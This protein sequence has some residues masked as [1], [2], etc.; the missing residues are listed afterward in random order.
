MNDKKLKNGL[1]ETFKKET[2]H[3]GHEHGKKAAHEHEQEKG[4]KGKIEREEEGK[5][6]KSAECG[7]K[8]F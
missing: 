1:G 5:M 2:G 6:K 4:G 8:Y 7:C 3:E